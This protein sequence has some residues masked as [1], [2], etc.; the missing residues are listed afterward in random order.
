[1][2]ETLDT[3]TDTP[4]DTPTDTLTDTPT[5]TLT[6]TPTDTLTDTP[7]DRII[8]RQDIQGDTWS[9]QRFPSVP[10]ARL[11]QGGRN[12]RPCLPLPQH[13]HAQPHQRLGQQGVRHGRGNLVLCIGQGKVHEHRRLSWMG[14]KRPEPERAIRLHVDLRVRGDFDCPDCAPHRHAIPLDVATETIV[15][16]TVADT[17]ADTVADTIADTL[18]D[19]LTGTLADTVADTIT[20]TVADTLTDTIT[21]TVADT[22]AD[23]RPHGIS[24]AAPDGIPN[25][26]S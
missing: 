25:V 1:M 24:H 3:L 2:P 23:T 15:A 22:V 12:L 19:T 4:T 18:T 5:D 10:P 26:C 8:G 17:I 20:D 16:D 11:R 7:T 13:L 6:D 21:D 14:N 9:G